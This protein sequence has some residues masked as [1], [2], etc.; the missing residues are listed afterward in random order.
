[1][2]AALEAG[3][4]LIFADVGNYGD[5]SLHITAVQAPSTTW[6]KVGGNLSIQWWIGIV[7]APAPTG[8]TF[9]TVG[10]TLPAGTARS[11]F[12]TLLRG[13][14]SATASFVTAGGAA[15]TFTS[16]PLEA[17]AGQAVFTVG[18]SDSAT[19]AGTV[20][21][22]ATG[23][24]QTPSTVYTSRFANYASR[25]PEQSETHTVTASRTTGPAYAT[26]LLVSGRAPDP[27]PVMG[28][29]AFV[30]GE[31]GEYPVKASAGGVWQRARVRRYGDPG[32]PLSDA[33]RIDAAASLAEAQQVLTDLGATYGATVQIRQSGAIG[34][35]SF[36][37][38]SSLADGYLRT[39]AKAVA[40]AIRRYPAALLRTTSGAPDGW[41]FY[42]GR[43]LM[44][45]G[46]ESSGLYN[47]KSV[48]VNTQLT[49]R[50]LEVTPDPLH[51]GILI[52][53]HE[54][55]HGL[56]EQKTGAALTT[57]KNEM[58]AAQPPGHTWGTHDAPFS[59]EH[60]VGFARWYS[61][62]SANEDQ[63]DIVGWMLT[64][65]LWQRDGSTWFVDDQ[66]LAAKA[67]AARKWLTSLG[68]T[69]L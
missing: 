41:A 47:A 49:A 55:A 68:F 43:T 33:D 25:L 56:W 23:W 32:W 10:S 34:V 28:L 37:N 57:F 65:H 27:E 19:N 17:G 53:H 45:S 9:R 35:A 31:W 40:A 18:Y 20:L 69:G 46:Q 8:W 50:Q 13:L 16:P 62:T 29:S 44:H 7:N 22:P 39:A 6:S 12:V 36:A 5:A 60:P 11:R 2:D 14:T 1:M 48:F 67:A 24:V 15:G 58:A 59:G 52:V 61:R 21:Q 64:D 26:A 66:Y 63:A 42:L 54:M 30:G 51:G 4:V 38:S 3:D